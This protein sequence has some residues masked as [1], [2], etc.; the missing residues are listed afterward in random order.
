MKLRKDPH[1]V[2][3]NIV[4]ISGTVKMK[5]YQIWISTY[6]YQYWWSIFMDFFERLYYEFNF[7]TN[8]GSKRKVDV[9]TLKN[10]TLFGQKVNTQNTVTTNLIS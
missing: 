4:F 5:V 3:S 6:T 1:K 8:F 7:Q 10:Y 2:S 9:T